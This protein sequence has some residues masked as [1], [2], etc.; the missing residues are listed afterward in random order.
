MHTRPVL[1]DL[2]YPCSRPRYPLAP[3][4]HKKK[5]TVKGSTFSCQNSNIEAKRSIRSPILQTPKP[6]RPPY[7]YLPFVHRPSGNSLVFA[8]SSPGL[9]PISSLPQPHYTTLSGPG[10]E[11]R[12][13]LVGVVVGVVVIGEGP[14]LFIHHHH[15]YHHHHHHHHH[16]PCHG[17]FSD[18]PWPLNLR[19]RRLS[20]LESRRSGLLLNPFKSSVRRRHGSRGQLGEAE[21]TLIR[22]HQ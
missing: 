7:I 13:R 9:H 4:L 20:R 2:K 16:H 17:G 14:P 12:I 21:A 15:Y 8:P 11:H 5:A 10:V 18:I 22:V 3:S 6:G 1:L 19:H